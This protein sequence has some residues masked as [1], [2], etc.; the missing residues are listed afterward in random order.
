M[1]KKK[2]GLALCGSYCTYEKL[3]EAGADRYLLRHET[4]DKAHYESLHP[5]ELSHEHRL[6]CLHALKTIGYQVG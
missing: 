5:P 2:L 4:A 1:E 3:F 6:K